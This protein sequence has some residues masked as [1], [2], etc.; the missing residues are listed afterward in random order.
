MTIRIMTLSRWQRLAACSALS[1][2]LYGC[3]HGLRKSAPA[4]LAQ[5]TLSDSIWQQ[6]ERNAEASDF[7]IHEHEFRMNDFRLNWAGEDHVKQI[8]ARLNGGQDFP[9]VIERSQRAPFIEA[10]YQYP[11]QLNPS[12][13][14]KRREMIVRALTAFNVGDAE[15]RVS[16]GMATVPGLTQPEAERAYL[17]QMQ[18]GRG[19]AGFGGGFNIGGGGTLGGGRFNGWGF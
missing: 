18:G 13:D 3:G 12:L 6:Q 16:V 1:L 17:N 9:V 4:P 8:A 10:K 19:G 15:E 2:A 14:M 5:G 11:V 7:V